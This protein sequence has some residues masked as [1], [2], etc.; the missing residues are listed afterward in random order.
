MGLI[1]ID[2]GGKGSGVPFFTD[3]FFVNSLQVMMMGG[4]GEGGFCGRGTRMDL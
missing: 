3:F 2:V 4:G 1:L